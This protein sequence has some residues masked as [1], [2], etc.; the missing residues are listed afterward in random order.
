MSNPLAPYD[1]FAPD[2][3]PTFGDHAK[4]TARGARGVARFGA[5]FF[6][7][8]LRFFLVIAAAPVLAGGCNPVGFLFPDQ[9]HHQI[10]QEDAAKAAQERQDAAQESPADLDS[11]ARQVRAEMKR[12]A[13]AGGAR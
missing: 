11:L 9:S 5:W 1:P 6:K 7:G 13:Q 3:G 10:A 12:Q 2:E 8:K 4:S